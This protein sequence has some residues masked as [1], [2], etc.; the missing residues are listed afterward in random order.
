MEDIVCQVACLA[1]AQ[2]AANGHALD[3]STPNDSLPGTGSTSSTSSLF[4]CIT[5]H[6]CSH[7]LLYY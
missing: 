2:L 7:P 3:G 4:Y 1:G 6:D 5:I